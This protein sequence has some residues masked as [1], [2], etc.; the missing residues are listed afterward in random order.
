MIYRIKDNSDSYMISGF[1]S[2]QLLENYPN[3]SD[4]KMIMDQPY[5]NESLKPFWKLMDF[6]MH[7]GSSAQSGTRMPDIALWRSGLVLMPKALDYLQ[8]YLA[9]HGEFLDATCEGQPVSL[10]NCLTFVQENM[11]ETII[12]YI[13]GVAVGVEHLAFEE[14]EAANNFIFKSKLQHGQF[15]YCTD[16]F[17]SLCEKYDLNGLRFDSD[18][19]NIF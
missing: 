6:S 8:D 3:I 15:L 19:M 10:F 18:I 17:K 4:V 16:D 2:K 5:T 13:D 1:G 7:D 12:E 14:K 9:P 11:D